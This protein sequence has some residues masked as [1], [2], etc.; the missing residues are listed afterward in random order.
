[1]LLF[2]QGKAGP[3]W[4]GVVKDQQIGAVIGVQAGVKVCAGFADAHMKHALGV[5][6]L[7]QEYLVGWASLVNQH[8]GLVHESRSWWED[9]LI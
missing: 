7:V 9:R 8:I 3:G 2:E 1:V 5:K 6:G 4:H